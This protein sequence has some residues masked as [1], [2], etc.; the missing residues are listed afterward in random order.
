[1]GGLVDVEVDFNL[2]ERRVLVGFKIMKIFAFQRG[3][4]LV[5]GMRLSN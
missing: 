2:L 4:L 1:M 5:Y 3:E